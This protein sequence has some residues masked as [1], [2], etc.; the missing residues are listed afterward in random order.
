MVG[1]DSLIIK[2]GDKYSYP[3]FNPKVKFTPVMEEVLLTL[4]LLFILQFSS[5]FTECVGFLCS[6]L[7]RS[8]NAIGSALRAL[9]NLE[10]LDYYREGR[11]RVIELQLNHPFME[12]SLFRFF[13]L[14]SQAIKNMRS[15]E[16]GQG[17]GYTNPSFGFLPSFDEFDEFFVF[18]KNE[19]E[20]LDEEIAKYQEWLSWVEGMQSL[21]DLEQNSNR[22]DDFEENPI[23]VFAEEIISRIKSTQ[24]KYSHSLTN[25]ELKGIILDTFMDNQRIPP[26]IDESYLHPLSTMLDDNLREW[27]RANETK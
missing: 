4:Q 9:T 2:K 27:Y 10:L 23:Q 15:Q 18:L 7:N 24:K 13:G 12:S 25:K 8:P 16:A 26:W 17:E 21:V 22:S 14:N 20:K 3:L 6:F 5:T 1:K 19:E 11:G